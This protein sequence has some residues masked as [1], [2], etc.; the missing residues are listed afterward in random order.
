MSTFGPRG[1]FK[2]LRGVLLR[3]VKWSLISLG[4][5]TAVMVVLA[6]TSLPYRAHRWLGTAGGLCEVPPQAII[7]LGGS[8]MPSGPELMRCQVA[9]ALG[10]EAPWARILIV[11][12]A[13]TLLAQAMTREVVW[14]GIDAERIDVLMG[15]RN[16]REQAL[17][18]AQSDP[19]LLELTTALVTAP[20]NMY[21][22][23]EAFRRVGATRIDGAPAFDHALTDDLRYI[24][25]QIGGKAYVPDVS[26]SMDLRY[27]F[28]NRI[29]LE[30]TCLREYVAIVY[31]RLNGWM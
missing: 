4:G 26:D 2:A 3:I 15:G 14:R 6:F 7:L 18:V 20:E 8:G 28:W 23:L 13:D 25:G 29:K 11:V 1:K 21:R 27:N 12:P 19:L 9:A 22:S 5:L 10:E 30:I 17:Q 24:H 16:T 31:Y